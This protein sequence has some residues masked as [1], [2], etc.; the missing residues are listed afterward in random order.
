TERSCFRS[1]TSLLAAFDV[2]MES[3]SGAAVRA[4]RDAGLSAELTDQAKEFVDLHGLHQV[5]VEA[6]LARPAGDLVATITG[7]RDRAGVC[8]GPIAPHELRHLVAVHAGQ[9][10]V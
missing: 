5:G 10:N 9:A 1:R 8:G 4:K 7:E 3:L 6:R 2:G